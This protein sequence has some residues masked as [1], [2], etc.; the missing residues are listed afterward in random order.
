M[1]IFKDIIILDIMQNQN[2]SFEAMN[3]FFF[4]KLSCVY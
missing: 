4:V 3:R 2:K 1:Y